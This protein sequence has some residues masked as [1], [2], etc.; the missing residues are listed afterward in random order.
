MSNTDC[1]VWEHQHE[2]RSSCIPDLILNN[3]LSNIRLTCV[4]QI[5][6]LSKQLL[7]DP[8]QSLVFKVWHKGGTES[9]F[10]PR[11]VLL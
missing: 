4:F 9:K 8:Q 7:V 11:F 3:L 10:T 2:C 5:S 1:P 6:R